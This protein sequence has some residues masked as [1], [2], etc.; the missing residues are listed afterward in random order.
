MTRHKAKSKKNKE[1]YP[2]S[3]GP[4]K[5]SPFAATRK[6]GKTCLPPDVLAKVSNPSCGSNGRCLINKSDLPEIEKKDIL[7]KYF[8]PIQPA[9]WKAKPDTWLT[10]DDITLVM[11]QFE[12][13]CPHYKFIGVVPIDFSYQDPY[14]K[15]TK[16]C[17]NP[18]FCMVDL[19]AERA[20][21][22]TV[23]GA[24]FNL[25]PHDKG[26]SH[27]VGLVIDLKRNKVY[28]FDSYGVKPPEQ[29]ARFMKYLTLQE[30][31][32][33]LQSN[34]RRFQYSNTECGVYSMYFIVCMINGQDFKTFC[35]NPIPDKWMY[36]FRGIFFDDEENSA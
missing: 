36:K 32:L 26:G 16:K 33:V 11:K 5:C 10:S 22:K 24:I 34:G 27:W 8:R 30:P 6:L 1:Q 23:L 17:I 15:S 31:K 2:K 3:P 18:E 29:V 28:F 20:A 35:K 21:G 9:E 7:K 25:D 12:E 19:K 14:D 13:G 4:K